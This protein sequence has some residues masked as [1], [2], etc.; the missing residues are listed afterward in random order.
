MYNHVLP[1]KML[2]QA[3]LFDYANNI[4]FAVVEKHLA[5]EAGLIVKSNFSTFKTGLVFNNFSGNIEGF[6]MHQYTKFQFFRSKFKLF[7]KIDTPS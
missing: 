3:T 4:V 5:Y 2:Q 7:L 6:S 1:V